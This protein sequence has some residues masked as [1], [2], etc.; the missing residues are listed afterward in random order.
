MVFPRKTEHALMKLTYSK[1]WPWTTKYING[2]IDSMFKAQKDI[3]KIVHVTLVAQPLLY[4]NALCVWLYYN[5][6]IQ[7]FFS[8][9]PP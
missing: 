6:F 2:R 4:V 5:E 1:L 8:L 9:A 7:Y 3:N